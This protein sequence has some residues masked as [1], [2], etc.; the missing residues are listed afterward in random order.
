MKR[1]LYIIIAVLFFAGL[2][3]ASDVYIKSLPEN[4]APDSTDAV[5][6]DDGVN[7][8]YTTLANAIIKAHGLSDGLMWV[9]GGVMGVT[10]GLDPDELQGDTVDDNLVDTSIL[11]T[12]TLKSTLSVDDLITLSGRAE[13]SQHLGTFTGAVIDDNLTV[14]AAFQDL[15]TYVESLGGGHD[16]VTLSTD[17]NSN[18]LGLSTQQLTLDSQAANLVFAG[19]ASGGSVA[20]SFRSLVAA[21]IPDLSATYETQLVNEVGLYAALSDVSDF[22]QPGDVLR[23]DSSSTLPG[24]CTVGDMYWDTDADS[25][26]S[27]YVCKSTNNWKEV[28][29]DG[30]GGSD[31]KVKVSS[32]ET[33]SDYLVNQIVGGDAS[34]NVAESGTGTEDLEITV[35]VTPGA[36]QPTLHIADDAVRVKFEATD[37]DESATG[38]AIDYTNAQA[39]ASGTKGFLTGTDWDTFNAKEDETHASEHAPGGAD[40]IFGGDPNANAFSTWDDTGGVVEWGQSSDLSYDG[41]NWS[42]VDDSHNHIYSNID[43]FTEANLY[44]ILSD[45]DQFYEP[46]DPIVTPQVT[47]ADNDVSPN[48]VGK[49]NYDNLITGLTDGGFVWYDD[50]EIQIVVSISE[51]D[52]TDLSGKDDYVLTYDYGNT[53]WY[54]A[55]GGGGGGGRWDQ[56]EDPDIDGSIDFG[57][58]EQEILTSIDEVGGVALTIKHTDSDGLT[59]DTYLAEFIHANDGD[60][61]AHFLRGLD[62]T[63]VELW[64]IDYAGVATFKSVETSGSDTPGFTARDLQ[65]PGSDLEIGKLTWNYLSGVDGAEDGAVYLQAMVAGTE[66]TILEYDADTEVITLGDSDTG[67]D[68]AWDFDTGVGDKISVASNSG[69]DEIDFNTINIKTDQFES[70]IT[71]GTPP[72]IVAS[73]TLVDNL[74]ADT[75]DGEEVSAIVTAARV[76]AVSDNLDDSDASIEWE[77]AADLD[78]GG[79]VTAASTTTAGKIESAIASEVDTGTST[80]LAVTPDSLA[81]SNYGEEVVGILVFDDSEDTAIADGAGDVFFR[82]PSKLNGWDLVEV[83]AQ[84]HTAGTTGNLDI[85]IYNRTDSQDFL[86]TAMRIESGETDTS[87]SAQPGTINTS[88]DDVATGDSIRIDVDAIQTGTAAKGLYV[89]LTFRLP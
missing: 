28:D 12:T 37:F 57:G 26:G 19:P 52:F 33:D 50:D 17:L 69:A 1:I 58:Y 70:D 45:V 20:P 46:N 76:G 15:E 34:I 6:I 49:F 8:E 23:T 25:D 77:D 67:E 42:V 16:P 75:V 40:D 84:V 38:L 87:T 39:A 44:T 78:S 82:I 13:G 89:E 36:A 31:E 5:E 62:N 9:S 71:T 80:T 68:L 4:T 74:N 88:Y 24:T 59:N 14:K 83:A 64:K 41:S 72:F 63:S 30:A 53:K 18:L 21:D 27:L 43:P 73:T 35:D 7:S 79:N 86:S 48:A 81:G 55:A 11:N 32:D 47:F 61:Q 3:A 60:A 22:H 2:S 29:D 85:M 54:L 51:N 65:C 56:I 66:R 10:T